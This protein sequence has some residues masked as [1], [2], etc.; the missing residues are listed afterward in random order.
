MPAASPEQHP[1]REPGSGSPDGAPPLAGLLFGATASGKTA[2]AMALAARLPMEVVS[3]DSR[4]V[5]RE[6]DIGTAKPTPVEIQAVPHHLLN[7]VDL[8]QTYNAAR[9]A[10]DALRVSAE[11]RARGRVPL[12]VG[13]AGFYLEVLREGLFHPPY[14]E[15]EL[16]E[17]RSEVA[18]WSTETMHDELAARDPERLAALHPNDRYRLSRALEICIASGSTVTALTESR[19]RLE[20][21]FVQFHL[22]VER[23]E[24]YRRIA[25]RTRAMLD[26]GWVDE[27]RSLLARGHAPGLP[28]FAT[29][30]YPHVLSH[31]AGKLDAERLAELIERDTRRF[32]RHQETWFRKARG[33]LP[34]RAG[35]PAALDVLESGLRGA[36]GI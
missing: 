15:A 17:V 2:L 33:A 23:A 10:D 26:A 14:S 21:R 31:L 6:L 12:V 29:L 4:Q 28:G 13:G 9:F 35:D 8:D 30:G 27:V 34:L 20:R 19:P 1:D 32:A 36:F 18:T 7:L 22:Q 5:Y 24:L 3:A 11:I 25:A 16:R